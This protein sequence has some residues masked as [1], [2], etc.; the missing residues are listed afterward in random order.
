M[1][2]IGQSKMSKFPTKKLD[3]L[4]DKTIIIYMLILNLLRKII[5]LGLNK[6]A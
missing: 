6:F 2:A 1:Y 5:N 3:I 4:T